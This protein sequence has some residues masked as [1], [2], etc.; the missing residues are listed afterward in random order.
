MN[1]S[2]LRF[3]LGHAFVFCMEDSSGGGCAEQSA[4]ESREGEEGLRLTGAD[5]MHV[6]W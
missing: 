2:Q 3:Y 6:A 4:G 5:S 1:Y